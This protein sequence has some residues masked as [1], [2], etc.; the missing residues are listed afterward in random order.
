[1]HSTLARLVVKEEKKE[2]P[3]PIHHTQTVQTRT[4][5]MT[6]TPRC[7]ALRTG[8]VGLII[9]YGILVSSSNFLCLL[10]YIVQLI[11]SVHVHICL[12]LCVYC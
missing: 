3:D 9:F 10:Q 12:W 2:N 4:H 11:T 7:P 1:M 8:M 6:R 5:T